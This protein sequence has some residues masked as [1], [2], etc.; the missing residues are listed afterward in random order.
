[1]PKAE[2][3]WKREAP[4]GVR[5][6]VYAQHVG[7]RWLFYRRERRYDQWQSLPDP[8]LEDWIELLD[9]VRR[10]IARRLLRPEEEGRVIG[11]IRTQYPEATL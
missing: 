2:I 8:P 10:R 7:N 1:M 4:D 9:A 5:W 3:S 6:Q 11:S